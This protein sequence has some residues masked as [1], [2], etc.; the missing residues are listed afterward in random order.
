MTS[1]V[2]KLFFFYLNQQNTGDCTLVFKIEPP[3]CT[4]ACPCPC[5]IHVTFT[6]MFTFMVMKHEQENG[7]G[8][9][10]GHGH[11]NPNGHWHSKIRVSD[12]GEKLHPISDII[13]GSS[14]I[15]Y[16][17]AQHFM[18]HRGYQTEWPSL[19][20]S[21]YAAISD[22]MATILETESWCLRMRAHWRSPSRLYIQNS[23]EIV[24]S[25]WLPDHGYLQRCLESFLQ[26]TKEYR[27][28]WGSNP[29]PW[30]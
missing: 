11:G 23:V 21:T 24:H 27:P 9:G 15:W 25:A 29:R 26:E 22:E 17:Q 14:S 16:H 19:L 20:H 13:S 7:N 10:H 5:R 8:H 6:Y 28:T 3:Q 4:C 2:Q 18:V 30:D 1:E 12:K